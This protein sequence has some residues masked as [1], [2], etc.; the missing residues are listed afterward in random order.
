L[1]C[2]KKEEWC[3]AGVRG[4]CSAFSPRGRTVVVAGVVGVVWCWWHVLEP[5]HTTI[6]VHHNASTCPS[7]QDDHH[8]TRTGRPH[9]TGW[10]L[11]SSPQALSTLPHPIHTHGPGAGCVEICS[12]TQM[13]MRMHTRMKGRALATCICDGCPC[14][15]TLLCLLLSCVPTH[16]CTRA[17]ALCRAD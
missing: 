1:E 15:H 8:T 3:G 13:H 6:M 2:V 16:C 5:G 14:S 9:R 7:G 17:H 11:P 12:T 10:Q 4:A